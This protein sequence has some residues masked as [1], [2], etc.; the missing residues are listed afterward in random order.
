RIREAAA[1]AASQFK[2]FPVG[3]VD[4]FWECTRSTNREIRGEAFVLLGIAC[5]GEK[6]VLD[7]IEGA[8]T[9]EDFYVRNRAHYARY[10]ATG[11]FP[12]YIAYL[13]RLQEGPESAFT[14]HVADEGK[15]STSEQMRVNLTRL[16]A[17]MRTAEWMNQRPDEL[18][19]ALLRLL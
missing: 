11:D 15:E 6:R 3:A 4:L 16:G 13:I 7:V 17:A 18:A 2:R 10:Q 1:S 5:R 19:A 9:D 8:K 14:P 12:A